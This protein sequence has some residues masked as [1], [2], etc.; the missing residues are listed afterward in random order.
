MNRLI[1]PFDLF[2]LPMSPAYAD[3]ARIGSPAW[4]EYPLHPP[5]CIFPT[6]PGGTAERSTHIQPAIKMR[7]DICTSS[8]IIHRISIIE[9][10]SLV[11]DIYG[12]ICPVWIHTQVIRGNRPLVM[13]TATNVDLAAGKKM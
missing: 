9:L 1:Y 7:I 12:N 3:V 5:E 13:A 2:S 10:S 11:C 8:P 6:A 4:T